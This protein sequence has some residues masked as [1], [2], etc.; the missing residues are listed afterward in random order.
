MST[1]EVLDAIPHRPPFLFVDRVVELTEDQIKAEWYL[2]PQLDFFR[3]HYPHQPI[4]PGVL[5]NEAI[6]QASAI[7]LVHRAKQAGTTTEGKTP[8]LSR[9]TDAR[10]REMVLPGDTVT[11]EVKW[12]E[13]MSH[14]H[15]CQGIV[16]KGNK[17]AVTL[18][19][20]LAMVG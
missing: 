20:A 17:R 11:L 15:F 13:S 2:D 8:V 12:K 6:F 4:V 3:G 14:F 1:Q 19:F 16:W 18:E 10:F 7:L 5:L 9:I